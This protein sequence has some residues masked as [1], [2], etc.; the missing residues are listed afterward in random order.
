[1]NVGWAVG[2]VLDWSGGTEPKGPDGGLPPTDA[3]GPTEPAEPAPATTDGLS[4][5]IAPVGRF[6]PSPGLIVDRSGSSVAI[7]G[8]VELFGSEATAARAAAIQD[9]INSMWTRSFGNGYSI[10]C[11]VAVR[12]RP[13]GTKPAD[14]TQIEATRTVSP[15]HVTLWLGRRTMTLNANEPDAFTWTSAHEFGHILGLKDRYSES[16]MSTLRGFV[17]GSRATVAQPGYAGNIMAETD[18]AVTRRSVSDLTTEDKPGLL[19]EDDHLAAWI[20]AHPPVDIAGLSP[21]DKLRIVRTLQSGWISARD[22]EAI[23]RVCASVTASSEA[24]SLRR[25]VD[26]RDFT[27]LG[28]R[29]QMRVFFARMP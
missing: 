13:Q 22:M 8:Q 18:G 4:G 25:G 15:S 1:M 23:G 2:R 20:F 17:G 7:S 10:S 3:G 29:T 6:S 24:D 9:A 21:A 16:I 14:V 19:S 28:Q 5:D 12:Y 26:L 27:D 11:N